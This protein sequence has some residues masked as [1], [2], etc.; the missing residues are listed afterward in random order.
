MG[1]ERKIKMESVEIRIND[2][3]W[4]EKWGNGRMIE[5]RQVIGENKLVAQDANTG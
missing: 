5:I 1:P 3:P 4:F 2:Q